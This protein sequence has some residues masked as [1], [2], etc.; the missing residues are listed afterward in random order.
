MPTDHE[1]LPPYA[2]A[3]LVAGLIRSICIQRWPSKPWTGQDWWR[4]FQLARKEVERRT[5]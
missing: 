3:L 4:C 1:Q 5:A 2:T